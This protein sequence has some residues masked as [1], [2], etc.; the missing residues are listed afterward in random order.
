VRDAG[1]ESFRLQPLHISGHVDTGTGIR[2][3][4]QELGDGLA[5]PLTDG[6]A[7]TKYQ[8]AHICRDTDSTLRRPLSGVPP[9]I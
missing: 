8:H 9:T 4:P 5:K 6:P 7:S 2:W 3:Y 1:N